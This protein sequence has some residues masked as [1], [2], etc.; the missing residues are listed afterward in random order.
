MKNSKDVY[1]AKGT[2][3]AL[4]KLSPEEQKSKLEEL[5][6]APLAKRKKAVKKLVGATLRG[7]REIAAMR[8]KF[9]AGPADEPSEAYDAVVKALAWVLGESETIRLGRQKM[10]NATESK[11][12]VA[13]EA[14]S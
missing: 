7:K 5:S 1:G 2:A 3:Y 14:L 9:I 4:A 8:E 6:T 13:E 10:K 11:N 12:G